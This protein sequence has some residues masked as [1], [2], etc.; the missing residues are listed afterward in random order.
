VRAAALSFLA[1]IVLRALPPP[2]AFHLP[3][4][5][6]P[7]KYTVELN[8][9]P[10][11]DTFIGSMQI[12][13]N[14][15]KP[16]SVVWLN[17]KNLV[18]ESTAVVSKGSTQ[19]AVGVHAVNDEFIAVEVPS[20][21]VGPAV[22]SMRY[23]GSLDDKAVVGA[24]RRQVEGEWYVYTTFTPIEARRVFPCFDELRM[25]A[26]W[27]ISIRVPR[28]EKAFSNGP[29]TTET[30]EPDGTKLIRFAATAPLPSE[31]V[32]FA[33]GPF[34]VYPARSPGATPMRVITP[35]GHGADGKAAAEAAVN[36]LP[37]LEAYTGIP[38]PFA[39][40]DHLALADAGFAAVENPGLIVYLA[41]ELL[42]A[43][44]TENRENTRAVRFLEA[45]E[46]G[47]Q[48]FGDMVTQADW[49]DV[50]LSE[51]FATW[52]SEKMMDQEEVAARAHLSAIATRERIMGVDASAKTH[53]VRVDVNSREDSLSIYNRVAYDKGASVL[54]MLEGWLGEEKF[55]DALRSY[56]RD[57][58]YGNASTR[59]LGDE[60]KRATGTDAAPVLH[61]FLDTT[62]IP[63]VRGQIVCDRS[64]KLVLRQTG[65]AAI[66]VCY[67]GDGVSQTCELMEGSS[68]EVALS[69]CPSW[70]YLNSGGTG[71]YRVAWDA[72]PLA[73]LPLVKL[74]PAE[75]LTLA[76]D[77]R[78][79]KTA[80]ARGVLAR[81]QSDEQPEIAEAARDAL[82]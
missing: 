3:G 21:F 56:L 65:A 47:H 74:T 45:H 26:S 50:W 68:R 36:L 82:K 39:K 43:P 69:S 70:I 4:D 15:L 81:L 7:L 19:V 2:P 62:G 63:Q 24:Y 27:E 64:D 59:D 31:L 38:Y 75:R 72:K 61:S 42:I 49:N 46:M 66:P 58:R 29:E 22:I 20:S 6:V 30:D 9:D 28:G 60:L 8:I 13:V 33:V 34:D 32:A 54:L 79:R 80:A 16:S 73:A 23:R 53:P 57:H 40:L 37:K 41:K 17:G 77:L 48:W 11:R 10:R 67:R 71:Y 12:E 55:R 5:V 18:P 1:A 76:Y 25:K 44:G 35:K 51:A 78:A 14:I 52:I